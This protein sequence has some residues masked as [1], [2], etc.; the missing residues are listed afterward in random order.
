MNMEYLSWKG[1]IVLKLLNRC[2]AQNRAQNHFDLLHVFAFHVSLQFSER[3][4]ASQNHP[5]ISKSAL[6][7]YALNYLNTPLFIIASQTRL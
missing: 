6:R 7:K 5:D 3:P 2:R 4:L 1:I